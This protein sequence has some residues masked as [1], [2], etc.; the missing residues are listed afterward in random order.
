MRRSLRSWL[1]RVEIGQE[2]DE[3]IAFHI[4]MRTRELVDKGV[5]PRIAREM[6]LARIGDAT[7][8]KRT[9]V[10]LGRKRDREMRITQWLEERRDDVKFAL[11]QL[12]ASPAFTL[13]AILTLALGIGAN[14]AMFALADA[15]LMRPLPYPDADRLVMVWERGPTF[16]RVQVSPVTLQDLGQQSGS[17]ERL[18]GINA[19]IGGGPLLEGPDG[20]LQSVDRQFVTATFFDALGVRPIAGRTFRPEEA[21]P[22]GLA[23][24]KLPGVVVMGAGL[25]R[26]RFGADSTLIGRAIR[27]NGEPFTVIGV[28]PDDV[29]LQRPARIWSLLPGIP[30]GL[31]A[32]PAARGARSLQVVARLKPGI[33]LE[34]A[35]ADVAAF[36]QRLA[37]DYPGTHKD[38]TMTVEPLR[39]AVMGPELQL[40]S[41]F[42]FGVVGFVLLLC[43]ANVA[44]LLLARGSVRSRE[45]AVRSALGAGRS[46]I[47]AQLLTES[48]VLAAFGGLLGF[49]VGLAIL[50][51]ALAMIPA[52]LLP[53]AARIVIDARVMLFCAAASITAGV[54]FGLIPA[55]QATRTA[56]VQ[57]IASE[58][59]STTRKGGRFRN[60]V[61][62]GEVAAAVLLLC[63]AGLL[64]RTLLVL[65]DRDPGYRADG[66]SVLTLDFS[67]APPN[68]DTR[69]PTFQSLMQFYDETSR[70]VSALPG[71][72]RI[73][74]TTSLPYGDSELPP[75]RFEIVGDPPVAIDN[76]PLAYFQAAS[77]GY[78][79]TLDLPIV[80]GRSFTERDIRDS[81][82]VCIVSEAFARR[83][84]A[85]REPVGLRVGI[86]R[87][88][89]ALDVPTVWEIVGVA[90]QV[91][92]RMSDPEDRAEVYVPLAQYPWTDTFLVVQSTDGPVG[93]LL[94]PIREAVARID[95]NVPVRRERTL[96][97]LANLTTAPHRFR[98]VIVAT[99]AT[100][101]LVLALVGIFGVLTYAVEQR[102]REFGVRIALGAT[103]ANVLKLVLGSAAGVIGLGTVVG[104]VAAAGL[105]Q[106]ISMFLFGV[107]P[108]DPVTYVSVAAVLSVTAALAAAAP[109]LRAVRVDP[110]EAFRNE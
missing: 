87:L 73:G 35:R 108:L 101:A 3:E 66:D 106:V 88:F 107:T 63:G 49:A 22:S 4:E 70:Q 50:K 59:R 104:L 90:R 97:D 41:L 82:A 58:S 62:A 109:A 77:P 72:S 43:C 67:L 16:P 84:L 27:L 100:L 18:G 93:A 65:G 96:N 110:V 23:P 102:T 24:G 10:D 26:T 105:G 86:D 89:P 34:A 25:W 76:R 51:L 75:Q 9:C 19:G 2:V 46:R 61:V 32:V 14:S 7:R 33:T 28:I 64:L 1:W 11:R 54:L 38:W 30:E 91:R 80:T 85:G 31:R 8:L 47:V 55:W 98:A 81:T 45:L 79:T 94:T 48:L 17:F 37:Q 5:D 103:T 92:G 15:T 42:L 44:N 29:Q 60:L 78:F 56:L 52:G 12:K 36:G 20:T 69:Y 83:Y 53:A 40:T 71:V 39:A 95:R 57:T 68:P 99:F 74:W 21:E 13:V 6:V